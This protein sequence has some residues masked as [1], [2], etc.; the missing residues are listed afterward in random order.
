MSGPM[1]GTSMSAG[2]SVISRALTSRLAKGALLVGVPIAA[3]VLAGRYA[4]TVPENSHSGFT[5]GAS[6]LGSTVAAAGAVAGAYLVC[7]AGMARHSIGGA[8]LGAAGIVGAASLGRGVV[9]TAQNRS[10]LQLADREKKEQWRTDNDVGRLAIAPAGSEPVDVA[11]PNDAEFDAVPHDKG[12]VHYPNSPTYGLLSTG[13]S[14]ASFST[15]A[16]AVRAM[17]DDWGQGAVVNHR[18]RYVHVAIGMSSEAELQGHRLPTNSDKTLDAVLND[19]KSG[20]VA[21]EYRGNVYEPFD[22]KI[23]PVTQW[24]EK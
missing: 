2:P 5:M 23:Y 4:P 1:F 3:S 15:E 8:I 22:G 16:D 19:A 6:A 24:E 9:S 18:G 21:F 12:L 10:E 14:L 20:V 13:E 11:T 7:R 17:V